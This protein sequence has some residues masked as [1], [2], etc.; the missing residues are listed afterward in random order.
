M[1]MESCHR[2]D[3][4]L[5]NLKPEGTRRGFLIVYIK[6]IVFAAFTISTRHLLAEFTVFTV[7]LIFRALLIFIVF[8]MSTIFTVFRIH[9]NLHDK[10]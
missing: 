10:K 2:R 8:T 1:A 9:P 7:R 3:S 5:Q 6:L 4:T